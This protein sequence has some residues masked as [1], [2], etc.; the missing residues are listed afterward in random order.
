MPWAISCSSS[1][2]LTS[3]SATRANTPSSSPSC[4]GTVACAARTSNPSETSRCWMPSCRSRS[5]R[6]RV[7]SAAA[8]IRAREAISSARLSAFAIA[9]ATSSVKEARRA[10]VSAGSGCSGRER[11]VITPQRRP[12]TMTGVPTPEPTPRSRAATPSGPE[13]SAGLSIRA[14][15]PVTK[16]SV[17]ML[18]PPRLHRRPTGTGR[19]VLPQPATVVIA[20]PGS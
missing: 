18:F 6:L 8:T 11:A 16:T 1:N 4:G 17:A 5:I 12:S 10:S 3:S 2:T 15:R 13:A 19:T 20:P 14:G 9:V 7:S